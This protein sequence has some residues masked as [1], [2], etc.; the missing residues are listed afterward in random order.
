MRRI[1]ETSPTPLGA[2]LS[3]NT[4]L[5]RLP[6]TGRL[7]DQTQALISEVARARFQRF[8]PGE[9]LFTRIQIQSRTGCNLSCSFCPANKRGTKLPTGQM[10]LSLFKKIMSDLSALEFRGA[11]LPYL[12]NEP[13]LDRRL[14]DFI[15]I[16][17]E[18]CPR[19]S[20]A[21][22]SNGTLLTADRVKSL[23]DSGIDM[24]HINDYGQ[25]R[26]TLSGHSK[27][28]LGPGYMGHVILRSR[29]ANE[30]LTNRAGNVQAERRQA[31]PLRAFCL[32]PFDQ[33]YIGYDGRVLL[34]CEDW[35]FQEVMGDASKK[36][37]LEIWKSEKYREVRRMLL[38]RD[39][40]KF[41]CAKC[42][43]QGWP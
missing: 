17:K 9:A 39:R 13:L 25:Q 21:I 30:K 34:C 16:A 24:I 23:V 29:R 1:G 36:S 8:D 15:R 42:D 32:R 22:E 18:Y 6:L 10:S 3:V 12:Q 28:E 26:N 41:I 14:E 35:R 37:L 11:L 2:L 33:L 4:L 31:L 5:K 19:A 7:K 43:F 40:T 38:R 27:I 20:I